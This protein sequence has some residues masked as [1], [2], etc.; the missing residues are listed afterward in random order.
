M[1]QLFRHTPTEVFAVLWTG[2]NQT[3]VR[4]L[5]DTEVEGQGLDFSAPDGVLVIHTVVGEL[6]VEPGTWVVRGP[7]G[8][9]YP[10]TAERFAERYEAVVPESNA[11]Q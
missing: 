2:G 5:A 10:L 7:D 3:E 4:D 6:K 8:E 9:L 11:A 1:R